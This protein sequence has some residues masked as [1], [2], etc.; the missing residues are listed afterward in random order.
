MS[1]EIIAIIVLLIIFVVGA[2][3]PINIGVLGLVAA[4]IV[5]TQISGLSMDEIYRIFPAE[6]FII[7]AGIT[8]LFTI[9][10]KS[11][12]IDLIA[13]SGLRLVK[14]KVS[15]TPWLMFLLSA[16]LAGVGTYGIAVVTLVAP[17]AL[18]IAYKHKI[19]PLMMSIMIIMGMQAGSF[20]PLNV[21]GVIVNGG[22]QSRDISFS[23]ALLL[24]N[25][26]IYFGLVALIAFIMFGGLR[27]FK[28]RTAIDYIAATAEIIQPDGNELAEKRES[29]LDLYKGACLAA[30][31]V[32]GVYLLGSM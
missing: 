30:I 5:G 6:L 17:I 7:M 9:I 10:Q 26:F 29:G 31:G 28:K 24:V 32:L 23:P 25:C 11:G 14:G 15:L 2:S 16:V 13:D 8:Y 20:S 19:N 12:V 18:K 21:F 1:L 27:F 22:M 3:L 4:Y